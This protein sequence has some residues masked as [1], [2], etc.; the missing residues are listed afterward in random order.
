MKYVAL[1]IL[2]ITQM[3]FGMKAFSATSAPTVLDF[4][5][6]PTILGAALSPSGQKIALYTGGKDGDISLRTFEITNKGLI[7]LGRLSLNLPSAEKRGKAAPTQIRPLWVKWID[8]GNLLSGIEYTDSVFSKTFKRSYGNRYSGG[9]QSARRSTTISS[10]RGSNINTLVRKSRLILTDVEMKNAQQIRPKNVYSELIQDYADIVSFLPDDPDHV[11]LAL[12]GASKKSVIKL[13][14]TTTKFKT[15]RSAW[16]GIQKWTADAEGN[17]IAGAG[18]KEK[19]KPVLRTQNGK[20]LKNIIDV[21]P[22][23][24]DIYPMGSNPETGDLY[25]Y[26]ATRSSARIV[27]TLNRET[28]KILPWKSA[29]RNVNKLIWNYTGTRV[30]GYEY[31]DGQIKTEFLDS[32]LQNMWQS[33]QSNYSPKNHFR[34][35]DTNKPGDKFLVKIFNLNDPGTLILYD[36]SSQKTVKIAD[37]NQGLKPAV[38]GTAIRS[39]FTTNDGVSIPLQITLPPGIRSL[40]TTKSIPFIIIPENEFGSHTAGGFSELPHFLASLGY[41][42]VQLPFRMPSKDVSQGN[43]IIND[44]LSTAK[45]VQANGYADENHICVLGKHFGGYFALLSNAN[46][47]DTFTCAVSISGVTDTRLLVEN[48]KKYYGSEEAVKTYLAQLWP[49]QKPKSSPSPVNDNVTSPAPILL[50]HGAYDSVADVDHAK[51]YAAKL[52]RSGITYTLVIPESGH[53][54]FNRMS[55]KLTAYQALEIFLEEQLK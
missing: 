3:T 38:L 30:I 16:P 54:D 51:N 43:Q 2:L 32:D 9:W 6:P 35:I 36:K 1:I 19:G 55:D 48:A 5:A 7:P 37:Y 10:N 41:G 33:V 4:A 23:G 12:G 46:S 27:K 53:H 50:I 42:V 34:L 18:I 40:E 45:W 17:I 13:N 49:N 20:K 8:E 47:P 52:K 21:L 28:G 26:Q 39:K 15:I 14:L 22:A 11:L 29:N 44:V 31:K 24:M 25:M